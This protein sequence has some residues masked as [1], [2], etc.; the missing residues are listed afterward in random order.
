[1]R[2]ARRD[3]YT[4]DLDN[5]YDIRIV[6]MLMAETGTYNDTFFRPFQ[7]GFDGRAQKLYDEFTDRGQRVSKE[8]LAG[9][10]GT[11]IRPATEAGARVSIDNGW[12]ERRIRFI[13][14][15]EC[16]IMGNDGQPMVEYITGYT[17]H[18]DF[19][20]NGLMDPRTKLYFNTTVQARRVRVNQGGVYGYQERMIDA[21]HVL[22]APEVTAGTSR[23][24]V[25]QDRLK[26]LTP[27]DVMGKLLEGDYPDDNVRDY[28]NSMRGNVVRKS[29]R[30]NCVSTDHL[31]RSIMGIVNAQRMASASAGG[32]AFATPDETLYSLAF[33]NVHDQRFSED[34]FLSWLDTDTTYGENRY[35][36]YGELMRKCPELASIVETIPLTSVQRRGLPQRGDTEYWDGSQQETVIANI[37]SFSVPGIM[38]E[39]MLTKFTFIISNDT[40]DGQPEFEL[41]NAGSIA[42]RDIDITPYIQSV[43]TRLINEVFPD[44]TNRGA[45]TLTV[46][47]DVD[48]LGETRITI[49]YNG[50]PKTD[51]IVPSFADGLFAPIIT[52]DS[53]D[54]TDLATAVKSLSDGGE[55]SHDDDDHRPLA[56]PGDDYGSNR[57]SDGFI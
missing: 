37:L 26:F 51:Y 25:D 48:I 3:E 35:I 1:M 55:S 7:S 34:R 43:E 38:M 54:L 20:M 15:V 56:L 4:D 44:V 24:Y 53:E 30:G 6:R 8:S 52:P 31:S 22:S 49:S 27:Q 17:D 2:S 9:I 18:A 36:T 57:R 50:G 46:F 10:A 13:M 16:G 23:R 45:M 29:R 21:S 40:L 28:R 14:V 33:E 47:M 11:I 39:L 42:A 41:R 19:S 5:I 12:G 32:D